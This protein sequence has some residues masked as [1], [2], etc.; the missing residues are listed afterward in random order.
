MRHN[1]R[2]YVLLIAVCILMSVMSVLAQG[3]VVPQALADAIIPCPM[4]V[5]VGETE[6]ETIICGQIEVQQNW[7]KP[8]GKTIN[9]SYAR[10]LTPNL[11]AFEDPVLFFE[12]GPGGSALNTASQLMGGFSQLRQTRDVILWDQRGTTYSG[13]LFCPDSVQVTDPA[14]YEARKQALDAQFQALDMDGNS[15]PDTVRDLVFEF[16]QLADR[17]L[18]VPYLGQQG[19]L[20]NQYNTKNTVRD[21]IA[22]M[23][24]LGYPAYNL[25]GISYGTTVILA[26]LDYYKKNP[27]AELPAIRSA[28]IE[29]VFPLNFDW[30]DA[31]N[32][33][34]II[35]RVFS[36]CEADAACNAAYPNIRQRAIDLLAAIEASPIAGADGGEITVD[37]LTEVMFAAI[38]S[39]VALIPYLPR[40]VDELER[41]E[42]GTFAVAQ[43]AA[44]FALTLPSPVP[45]SPESSIL[46][47]ELVSEETAAIIQQ[48]QDIQGQL[49]TL[50][51]EDAIINEAVLEADTRPEVFAAIVKAYVSR[52]GTA[53]GLMAPILGNFV[54][55]PEQRTRD[56]LLVVANR[57][58]P[59][60]VNQLTALVDTFTD[61][62]VAEVFDLLTT[63]DFLASLITLGS[64]TNRVVDCN[65]RAGQ[66][67]NER[68]FESFR[69]YEVPQLLGFDVVGVVNYQVSCE[70]LGLEATGYV[71]PPPAVVSDVPTLVMS[72][73]LDSATPLEWGQIAS[74]GLT[75]AKLVAIPYGGHGASK[76]T[77]CGRALTNAFVLSPNV[78]LNLSC[79]EELRT[80]FILPDD[81][82][83][84]LPE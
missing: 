27:D 17:S 53:R 19:I 70:Q 54:L 33:A 16:A 3:T 47:I 66:L 68:A 60:L 1:I 50:G 41:G 26:I 10:F 58:L 20:V 46:G 18:C 48:L 81:A 79:V 65:D 42:T 25:Y 31:F 75:N 32:K 5:P 44:R 29:G 80:V 64:I 34:N 45:V 63:A 24:H 11:A 83:P 8:D 51:L 9:I 52:I 76:D 35:L 37:D 49:I 7:E 55:Y 15:D 72:G 57:T 77:A 78:E 59:S 71:P 2:L 38:S 56:G 74:E 30:T 73:E 23:K 43:A 62:E 36:G 84:A 4:G 14:N 12:G 69:D 40:M 6:G 21:S 22:L 61:E 82:L 13:E 28:A 39:Q 67:L